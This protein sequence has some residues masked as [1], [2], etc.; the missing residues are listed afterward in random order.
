LRF[1]QQSIS[2]KTTQGD[3]QEKL[4]AGDVVADQNGVAHGPEIW[5]ARV[6]GPTET[7]IRVLC[8]LVLSLNVLRNP[9]TA[10]GKCKS[11]RCASTKRR[12]K[13]STRAL[14][15]AGGGLRHQPGVGAP[16]LA[17]LFVYPVPLC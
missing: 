8:M 6:S 4:R 7:A 17:H 5:G 13:S 2:A 14:R 10:S 12:S 3:A 1:Q 9:R 16:N 15:V 11:W